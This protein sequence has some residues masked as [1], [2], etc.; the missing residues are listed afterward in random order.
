[1]TPSIKLQ[2]MNLI[3]FNKHLWNETIAILRMLMRT[4]LYTQIYTKNMLVT[5]WLCIIRI[6]IISSI[7]K[8]K[9]IESLINKELVARIPKFDMKHFMAS[10][11]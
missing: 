4:S 2:M 7:I 9:L 3:K 10:L 5:T 6:V 1:M 11:L 8:I